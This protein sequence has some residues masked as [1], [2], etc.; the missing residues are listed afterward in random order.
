MSIHYGKNI[1]TRYFKGYINN[2]FTVGSPTFDG[3]VVSGFST[4][5]Y[6]LLNHFYKSTDNA[7]YVFKF[8]TSSSYTDHQVIIHAEYFLTIELETNGDVWAY[9][10][11]AGSKNVFF[12]ASTN[13]DYWVKV[14]INGT[15][16][17]CSYST[18]GVNFT[19]EITFTDKNLQP[20]DTSYQF[21]FGLSSYN[22]YNP[23]LGS[24]DLSECYAKT[25][26]EYFWQP[27]KRCKY[28]YNFTTVGTP[29]ISNAP[30]CEVS[31]FSTSNYVTSPDSFNPQNNP[32][33][34]QVCFTTGNDITTTQQVVCNNV[35]YWGYGMYVLGGN[36]TVGLSNGTSSFTIHSSTLGVTTN[37]KYYVKTIFNGSNYTCQYST[38]GEYWETL[39]S[40]D[41][42]TSIS[43]GIRRF[44]IND[45]TNIPFLGS[46]DLTQS[47]IKINGELWWSCFKQ[48]D[49]YVF[50]EESTDEDYDYT[51]FEDGK[52]K[53]LFSGKLLKT[54]Y[55]KYLYEDWTQP[56][57]TAST[58]AIE[59]GDMVI[60]ASNEYPTY[61]AYKALDGVKTGTT[62][63]TGWGT[64]NTTAV[65][66]WQLKL[67]YK[68]KITGLADY[69]RYDT[70]PANA[71]TIGRFYTSSDKTTPIGDEYNNTIATNWN[72]VEVT[73]IP[74]K[75]VVTDTI[76][77]EKTGG[78]AYGGLGELEITAQKQIGFEESTVDD[79]DFSETYKGQII[80][81][82]KGNALVYCIYPVGGTIFEE[83]T[84]GTYS[85]TPLVTGTYE[86]S[87]VGPGSGGTAAGDSPSY[88]SKS[89]GAGGGSGAYVCGV[90]NLVAG[91]P[92][93]IVVGAG[94]PAGP[95]NSNNGYSQAAGD[96]S[97]G[98]FLVCGGGGG[99]TAVWKGSG[100]GGAGGTVKTCE[101]PIQLITRTAGNQ[102]SAGGG[103]TYYAGGVSKL[104]P[105]GAGGFGQAT[106]NY[107]GKSSAGGNG[108]CKIRFLVENVVEEINVNFVGKE[109]QNDK[110]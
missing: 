66:W 17:T 51:I 27:Y 95:T 15:T 60:T 103:Y 59:G 29:S 14:T 43:G 86:I 61:N 109:L 98:D 36:L 1:K 44:G 106:G 107:A 25:N 42:T 87:L 94:G 100:I 49:D 101:N 3:S 110:F 64:Y 75:G 79:Y 108:Y 104:P 34:E 53:S 11:E 77:F 71:N 12:N 93:K 31:G 46:I 105:H 82:Y 74:E 41:S 78:G 21:R 90:W 67:P 10:W 81:G 48:S 13:T 55:F 56:V 22:G 57:A 85:F 30:S 68:I 62:A 80:L 84:A 23:F 102:G 47:Y 2:F 28:D 32:W 83:S 63:T 91:T 50:S 9:N 4:S 19:G 52:I 16:K 7:E 38:D 65:Q 92:Y 96:S 18:D 70:T 24:I 8:R 39:F 99:A 35:A 5:N 69:Q 6:L 72:R 76:Y 73:G 26:G 40:I 33:E 37:T 89:R 88:A 54:K 20:N 58:T 45:Q 97:F